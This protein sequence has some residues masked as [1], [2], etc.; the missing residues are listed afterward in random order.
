LGSLY[1]AL[2][3]VIERGKR[4]NPPVFLAWA[5]S[6]KAFHVLADFLGNRSP[7]GMIPTFS[8]DHFSSARYSAKS[9]S[10]PV[11]SLPMCSRI[12]VVLFFSLSC[13]SLT[14]A[15]AAEEPVRADLYGDPLPDGAV[16][17]LGTVRFRHGYAA[18]SVA[19][20]P[21]G[22]TVASGELGNW[23]HLWDV[24]TGRERIRFGSGHTSLSDVDLVH[25]L[26]FSPDGRK[27]VT[28]G[29]APANAL[30]DVGTGKEIFPFRGHQG[31][32]FAVAYSSD[33]R[34]VASAGGDLIIRLWN[35]A[36]GQELR[37]LVGHEG[38]VRALAFSPDG[39]VLASCGETIRLWGVAGGKE[40]RRCEGHRYEVNTVAFSPDGK[41]LASGSH[42]KTIRLWDVDSG[43]QLRE[44][45]GQQLFVRRLFPRRQDI[46]LGGPRDLPVRYGHAKRSPPVGKG[47]GHVHCLLPGW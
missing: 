20:S 36:T 45:S 34:T 10:R 32:V 44:L 6:F 5:F 39:A 21:D 8:L 27:I 19:F 35:T 31:V 29:T 22:K 4:K 2:S 16:A 23:V 26:A 13:S 1:V 18:T 25:A 3:T 40:L 47:R 41:V 12:A 14:N 11:R 9:L 43:K 7:A 28:G 17:R 33:N 30:W 42:D 15:L 24:A 37:Q 46:R 38:W